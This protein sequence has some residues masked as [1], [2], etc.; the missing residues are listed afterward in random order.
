VSL[1]VTRG[2]DGGEV[3]IDQH[4]LASAV[5]N[6]IQ[7]AFKFTRANGNVTLR[8]RATADRLFIDVE[9]E[10]GGLPKG[11][12]EALFQPYE[13]RSEDRSGLGLGL[14]ISRRG[15]EAC[16]GEM[17]VRDLPGK[18]CV[19]TIELPRARRVSEARAVV[20]GDDR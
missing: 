16:G 13:Q 1:T 20:K 14:T 19:F 11:G 8:T 4:I 17:H 12:G 5:G 2:D 10:C 18:G 7:N 15:V 3:E 6:L 9:D